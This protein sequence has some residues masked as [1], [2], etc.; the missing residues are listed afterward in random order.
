MSALQKPF[1]N[2]PPYWRLATVRCAVYAFV[3]GCSSFDAGVEGYESFADMTQMQF[4][5]LWL[6]VAV[7]MATVW[8]AFLDNSLNRYPH[9]S[10]LTAKD[11]PEQPASTEA[12]PTKAP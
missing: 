7:S 3:V 10:G 2:L 5:R 4:W 1:D 9:T 8:V 11:F 6:Q 12:Q